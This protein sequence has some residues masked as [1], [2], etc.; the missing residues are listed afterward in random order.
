MRNSEVGIYHVP[1]AADQPTLPAHEERALSY[2]DSSHIL[3]PSTPA[4]PSINFS[5]RKDD[6]TIIISNHDGRDR[7][8]EGAYIGRLV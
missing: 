3:L 4:E 2:H 1:L 5:C 6:S 8:G 7:T